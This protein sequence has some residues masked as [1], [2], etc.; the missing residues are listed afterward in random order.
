MLEEYKSVI[1]TQTHDRNDWKNKKINISIQSDVCS[2]LNNVLIGENSK[3]FKIN[4]RFSCMLYNQ[5]INQNLRYYYK[6]TN[7]FF[8]QSIIHN[9]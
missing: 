5:S 2:I 8:I 4:L 3:R 1:Q 6:S 7:Q 9:F